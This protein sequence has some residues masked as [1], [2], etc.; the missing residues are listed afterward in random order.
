MSKRLWS[1]TL[2]LGMGWVAA[3]G[4]VS[5]AKPPDLPVFPQVTCP[6]GRIT[7][8]GSGHDT[9]PQANVELIPDLS[10]A[11]AVVPGLAI[12]TAQAVWLW[13]A[14]G[15]HDTDAVPQKVERQ[16][17]VERYRQAQRIFALGMEYQQRGA[18]NKAR[19]CFQEAHLLSPDTRFGRMAMQRLN[20]LESQSRT[21]DGT[22]DSEE[23]VKPSRGDGQSNEQQ[24]QDMLRRTIPLGTVPVPLESH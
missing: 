1:A 18:L 7:E 14:A 15:S 5:S 16:R 13:P 22:E 17:L 21:G 10:W 12:H 11:Q 19:T 24:Y 6:E 20:D 8:S 4:P 9:A 3:S 23:R 2:A